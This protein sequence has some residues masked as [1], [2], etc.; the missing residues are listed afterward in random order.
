[1][2]TAKPGFIKLLPVAACPLVLLAHSSL[3]VA[4]DRAVEAAITRDVGLMAARLAQMC[5]VAEAY[6][7]DAFDTCRKGL[8]VSPQVQ[9]MLG[10]ITLWGRQRE[11]GALLKETHL[12]QFAPEVLTGMYMPLFMFDGSYSVSYSVPNAM[13][14]ARLGVGFRNRLQPGQFPYPFWHEANKWNTYENAKAMLFWFDAKSLKAR[15]VQ[16]TQL[17]EGAP[18]VAVQPVATPA[19]EGKWM[20]TDAQG[21]TQPAVTLFDGLFSESNPYKRD[22]D[23]S[24]RVLALSLRESQCLQCHVPNN[25]QRST[26]LVLLQSP[27]HAAAEIKRLLKQ[28]QTDRMPVDDYGVEE[29]LTAEAKTLLLERG[30]VF[31]QFVDKAHAWERTQRLSSTTAA[32]GSVQ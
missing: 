26:K 4:Q 3:A 11:Q 31:E 23:A 14:V 9:A 1:M 28:V 15:V 5:P 18:L 29:S 22:L 19:F 7:Q 6:S 13:Y 10:P 8:F 25:P 27:A 2:K 32:T 24:Y 12:T 21:K 17:G 30:R 20:W 16:F